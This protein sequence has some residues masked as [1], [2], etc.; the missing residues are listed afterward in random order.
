[1]ENS[2]LC[3]CHANKVRIS[4]VK[5]PP[6]LTKEQIALPVVPESIYLQ[7]CAQ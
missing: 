7:L 4:A 1:M 2:V 6:E 3:P 5:R